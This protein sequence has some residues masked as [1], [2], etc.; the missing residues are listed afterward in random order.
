MS[1]T[2]ARPRQA[3]ASF[4]S[5]TMKRPAADMRAKPIGASQ[6]YGLT[7]FHP[8]QIR[9]A[10]PEHNQAGR[11]AV[12]TGPS[13][14]WQRCE[15]VSVHH[16]VRNGRYSGQLFRWLPVGLPALSFKIGTWL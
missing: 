16:A 7:H 10:Y 13:C 9:N 4:E 8:G 5:Q 15:P 2:T 14:R 12:I 3:G 1:H 6:R 11:R